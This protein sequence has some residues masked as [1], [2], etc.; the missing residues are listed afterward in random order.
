MLRL[1]VA[2]VGPPLERQKGFVLQLGLG[3][4][5]VEFV[6]NIADQLFENVFDSDDSSS[7]TK[8]VDDNRKMAATLFEFL[9]QLGQNFGLRNN[10]HIVHDLRDLGSRNPHR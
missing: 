2:D 7:R 10:Q 9:Q 8:L 5:D 3:R 6:F 4:R 1:E